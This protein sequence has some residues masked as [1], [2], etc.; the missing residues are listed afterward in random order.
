MSRH[1]PRIFIETPLATGQRLSLPEDRAHH[2]LHVL[3]LKEGAAV[4]LFD[5]RGGEFAATFAATG[6]RRAEIEVGAHRAVTRESPLRL[7]LAQA[8]SR[9]ERM[10]YTIQKA[11]ELGVSGIQP[12]ITD[13]SQS[14]PDAVRGERKLAHWREIARSAAEQCGRERVPAVAAPLALDAWLAVVPKPALK[15]LLDPDSPAGL[16]A[17]ARS[18]EIVLLSGPEG[19]LSAAESTQAKTAGFVALRLG[20]RI[21]RTETAAVAALAVL[22]A[23]WGDLR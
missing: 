14:R 22:Q 2:L 17:Q 21:L 8:I 12:V 6:K 1:V 16:G 10:D 11:V 15:L 7:T 4:V 23:Q 3:R 13:Y 18:D 19:G 5:G 20:P 9:G